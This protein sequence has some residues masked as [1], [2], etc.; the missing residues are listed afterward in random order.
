MKTKMTE[1]FGIERPIMLAGM[2][3]V[4]MPKLIAAVSNAGGLGMLATG[5][6]TP[7]Q[8]RE[9]IREIRSLTDKPFAANATLI[10]PNAR[11]NAQVIIEEKVPV[12]NYA[13]GRGDWIIKGVHEYGGKVMGTV[14]MMRHAIRSEKDGA[15]ALIVTGHEAAAHGGD[16]TTMVLVRHMAREM[17]I[18]IIAAGGFCDGAGLVAALAIGAEGISMGTRL[19]LTQE[20]DVHESIIRLCHNATVEDTLYT[21]SVDGLPGRF[22]KTKMAEIMGQQRVPIFRAMSSAM[23]VKQMTGA[24]WGQLISMGMKGRSPAELARQAM[25]VSALSALLEGGSEKD[26]LLPI[27]Q[28][29]GMIDDLPTVKELFDRIMAEAEEVMKATNAK[30]N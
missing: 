1:L 27:G 15:D 13:L 9:A 2:S 28:V 16:V 14:V 12:V 19:L 17:S 25:A 10:L 21:A 6:L 26:A 22:L 3:M 11:E 4:A 23:E 20:A 30:F 29:T 7:D 24:S 5:P 8:T 18:P